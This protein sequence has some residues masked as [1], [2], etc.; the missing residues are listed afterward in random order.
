MPKLTEED[1][2]L[3][4]NETLT[5]K[6]WILNGEGK[7]VWRE[8]NCPPHRRPAD[9]VLCDKDKKPLII[10]EVKRQGE[11]MKKA[12][13]QGIGYAEIFK[14]P[15]VIATDSTFTK[16]IHVSS[17]QTL[18]MNNEDFEDLPSEEQALRFVKQPHL[19]DKEDEKILSRNELI[20]VFEEVNELLR[21]DVLQAG[22][23]RFSEFANILFLKIFSEVEERKLKNNEPTSIDKE[24]LWT[25][26]SQK[27]GKDLWKY[28]NGIVLK[29]F[30]EK[31][32][33]ENL[34]IDS[35]IQNPQILEKIIDK[36]TPLPFY[37]TPT[38]VKG[39]AFEHFLKR[40]NSGEKDLGEYFTPRHIVKLLVFLAKPRLKGKIYD[41]FCGTGGILIEAFKSISKSVVDDD[42]EVKEI[43]SNSIRGNEK[44]KIA[45]I[46][47]MN[48]I[49][50]GDGHNNIEQID[51]FQCSLNSITSEF[52]VVITNIPFGLDN[53]DYGK[54]KYP[55]NCKYGDCLAIQHC[56]KALKANGRA[57][58]IMP[59]NF[60]ERKWKKYQNTRR[61]IVENYSIQAIIS[62]PRNVFLP[63]TS[64]NSSIIVVQN[65][66][67]EKD[68]F[69]YFEIKNDGFTLNAYRNKIEGVVNDV[70]NLISLWEKV[71]VE[72]KDSS[73][74]LTKIYYQDVEKNNWSF[75]N[76]GNFPQSNISSSSKKLVPLKKI[77]TLEHGYAGKSQGDGEFRFIQI[78]DI[79]NQGEI[80]DNNK[81][82]ID[83]PESIT[84]KEKL[85]LKKGEIIIAIVGATCGKT[86]IFR[87]EEKAIFSS[88]LARVNIDKEIILPEYLFH[89][90][91]SQNFWEKVENIKK[92]TAQPYLDFSSLGEITFPIP[93][94]EEQKKIIS[95]LNKIKQSIQNAQQIIDN[96]KLPLFVSLMK[97]IKTQKL[98]EIASFEYGYTTKASEKGKYRFIQ[99]G[100]ISRYGNILEQEKKYINLP[101][102]ISE[103]KFLLKER[104][105]IVARHG[106]CGRTAIFQS[107]EKTIF[108]NDLIRI[109]FNKEKILP[110]YYWCFSQT[111]E[112]WNQVN[113]LIGG[114]AQPQFNAN[115]LKEIKVPIPSLENQKKAVEQLA[116]IKANYQNIGQTVDNLNSTLSLSLSAMRT[117]RLEMFA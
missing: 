24:D 53:V 103:D 71:V 22:D 58:L 5:N 41:P 105:I 19:I 16:A 84:N 98:G 31:Y 73:S 106:N 86:G 104:D 96:F 113:S 48:M 99:T 40:Y 51:T 92:G 36:L 89:L 37:N 110:E 82:Y 43:L 30:K 111:P 54:N 28:V 56:L 29:N 94:L 11:D 70:E 35:R 10:I 66:K 42:K 33:K 2:K 1:I 72:E 20:K 21:H 69:W 55:I 115:V 114:T 76:K 61:W 4:V 3:E 27:R 101:D 6:G 109:K 112:Y 23:E 87:S 102:S 100:D 32:K 9:Y 78:S 18:T 88:N 91:Q 38:D 47:K 74:L 62:L 44:T 8:R 108:T 34:F 39:E 65:K 79:N 97:P 64:S 93:S 45:R 67:K 81:K 85:L 15:L 83:L 59:E 75:L 26:F 90:F 12:L 63:Y 95:G 50:F 13:E 68:F 17:R 116:K 60:F 46:A 57:V 77:A 14:A 80:V 25:S 107:N 49:L 52:D 117:E 7:N